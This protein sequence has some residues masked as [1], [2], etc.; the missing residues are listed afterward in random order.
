MS[1]DKTAI[2]EANRHLIAMNKKVIELGAMLNEKT[3]Q[4]ESIESVNQVQ[5]LFCL[6]YLKSSFPQRY[7]NLPCMRHSPHSLFL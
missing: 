1:F 7:E 2:E 6:E 3:V 5:T 4:L